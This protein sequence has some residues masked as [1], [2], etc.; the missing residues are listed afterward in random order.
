MKNKENLGNLAALFT[1]FIWGT[2]F[3]STKILLKAMSPLEILCIRFV[4]GY[5]ALWILSPHVLPKSTNRQNGW[6]LAAGFSGICMYY[7]LE[8]IALK[9]TTASS[10]GII[11]STAPFFTALLES[12]IT[13][14]EKPKITFYLGFLLAMAGIL[15]MNFDGSVWQFH[16][17]G[18]SLALLA[19]LFWAVYSI[20]IKKIS[21]LG[22][23]NIQT[24]R[25]IF[26]FGLVC[27]FI[28]LLFLPVKW[29]KEAYFQFN[30]LANILYLGFFASAF[31]FVSWN[32]AVKELGALRTSVFIY[33]TP[34]ITLISSALILKEPVTLYSWIG[35]VLTILGLLLSNYKSQKKEKYYER[36]N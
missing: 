32:F 36:T 24:T 34:V 31:C 8:N 33:L 20:L 5:L 16:I 1:I 29:N 22:Y 27:M 6:F 21:T 26:F 19:A 28:L 7:L 18:D 9:Y 30:Y 11:I 13:K 14:E 23:S 4:I 3:I 17:K 2:T 12:W 25:R 10:V 15:L 35:I